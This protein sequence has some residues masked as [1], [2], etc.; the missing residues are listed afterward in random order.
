MATIRLQ[1]DG[2]PGTIPVEAFLAA[3]R[4]ELAILRDLDAAISGLPKGSLQWVVK[5]LRIGSTILDVSS[6]STLPDED[7][8]DEVSRSIVNS[9]NSIE[10]DNRT[11]AY[12]SRLG[13]L[14]AKRLIDIPKHFRLNG[15]LSL[16]NVDENTSA[17]VSQQSTK[18]IEGLL[19]VTQKSIGSIEGRLDTVSVHTKPKFIL[20]ENRTRRA[21]TC[22]FDYDKWID[23][24]KANLRVKVLVSGELL[25]NT[26]GE[27][28]RIQVSNIAPLSTRKIVRVEDLLGSDPNFTGFISTD[29]HIR[30]LRSV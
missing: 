3:A 5:D 6:K 18:N 21:I 25:S 11:P 16:L 13:M 12:L 4:Y 7:F 19:S 27:T 2:P 22:N 14:N 1:I 9:I 10:R 17:I 29:E 24:V 8:G 15:Q 28:L 23:A 20:Y 26:R 30:R